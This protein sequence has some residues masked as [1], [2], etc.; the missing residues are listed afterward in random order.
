[1]HSEID[2]VFKTL[3]AQAYI[4]QTLFLYINKIS[5]VAKNDQKSFEQ[6]SKHEAKMVPKM[7][8][9]APESDQKLDQKRSEKSLKK[10]A[11]KTRGPRTL[12]RKI[13]PWGGFPPNPAGA[14]P[15]GTH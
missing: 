15:T 2:L 11:C 9:G 12:C 6:R 4:K 1:M 14:P 3:E 5:G 7:S 10:V 13:G 8:P